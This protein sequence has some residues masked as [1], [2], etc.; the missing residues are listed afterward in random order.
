MRDWRTY[1]QLVRLPNVFT[2]PAD[3]LLGASI[4]CGTATNISW[5]AL[6][7]LA[8][9]S[10][11]LY[12]A[13][14]AWNDYFDADQ[15][16]RERPFRPV[17]SGRISRRQAARIG[18]SLLVAG[19]ATA[20][21][22]GS[23]A[24]TRWL[25]AATALLLAGCVLLYDGILKRTRVGPLG[26][27]ACRGLNVMLGSSLGGWV[28]WR[29][30]AWFG[31][32]VALYITGLTWFARGE[33]DISARRHLIGGALLMLVALAFGLVVPAA[34]PMALVTAR[35]FAPFPYLVVALGFCVGIPVCG[36][37]AGPHSREVQHAVRRAIFC[38]VV[39]DA[40]LATTIIGP[41]GLWILLLLG[42]AL[43]LGRWVY[44]T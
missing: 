1:A 3:V 8:L 22:A 7:G 44:S 33:A 40:A 13:G 42:P 12:A 27:G 14:M 28:A 19:V 6:L 34:S 41:T 26:M 4:A 17:P 24:F 32:V 39:L 11:F 20:A 36:A 10:A 21:I 25:A 9:A 2:A 15:D 43:F 23:S 38:L 35:A 37:I 30:G 5:P 18:A 29:A 31:L 16:L